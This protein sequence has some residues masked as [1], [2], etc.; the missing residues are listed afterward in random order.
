M[1]KERFRDSHA[2]GPFQVGA[3]S[4]KPAR[5]PACQVIAEM[6]RIRA[7]WRRYE[8]PMARAPV[9]ER[10]LGSHNQPMMPAWLGTPS[11]SSFALITA[12]L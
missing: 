7:P 3:D 12:G 5:S 2:P 1:T 11:C 8:R 6:D 9:G 10:L 4:G